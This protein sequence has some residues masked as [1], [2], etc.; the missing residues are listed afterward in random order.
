M[1]RFSICVAS[2]IF[3]V[4]FISSLLQQNA[5]AVN[6]REYTLVYPDDQAAQN[7]IKSEITST[8]IGD[9]KGGLETTYILVK[10]GIL[11]TMQFRFDRDKSNSQ[12]A[13]IYSNQI[14][15]TLP[16]DGST[17]ACSASAPADNIYA[18]F[19]MT[20]GIDPGNPN[21]FFGKDSFRAAAGAWDGGDKYLK[22]PNVS[23]KFDLDAHNKIDWKIH[24]KLT[25]NEDWKDSQFRGN[26]P[27]KLS[28]SQ[29]DN[30]IL[31]KIM[32]NLV[33]HSAYISVFQKLTDAQKD[34]WDAAATT[35]G[36]TKPSE[37][38]STAAATSGDEVDSCRG[39][40]LGWVL[41]PIVD[42]FAS[43]IQGAGS[44]IESM[45]TFRILADKGDG[46]KIQAI[47]GAFVS[48]ANILLI[49]AFMVI[50]FSQS[51]S[52]GLS[53]Y[54]I[55]RMLPRL[56]MGAIFIN[57]SFYI[58]AF[59]IDIS[60]IAG[61]SIVGFMI[62]AGGGDTSI[63]AQINEAVGG[64][65]G[66]VNFFSTGGDVAAGT[67]IGGGLLAGG[68]AAATIGATALLWLAVPLLLAA[69]ISIFATMLVLIAR[70]VILLGLV[71]VSPL[72]F[73]AWLLPNTDQYF[74]KWWSLFTQQL[75]VFPM[76]MVVFGASI[77]AASLI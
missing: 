60:N 31:T 34:A 33:E 11:G 68:V 18:T 41:C 17:S 56:V 8:G 71:L 24:G 26:D 53:N 32:N 2:L 48:M 27:Y 55:K 5:G 70:Q 76:L 62:G 58:C 65:S 21:D 4:L 40:A 12:D 46:G 23:E 42:G 49:V 64:G 1:K 61:T 63:S 29:A 39:G 10:D 30:L 3:S 14:Y 74:R 54:G 25:T 45:L 16:K 37:A 52:V 43:A 77:L 57:L 72:A 67:V 59:L 19:D 13:L 66:G 6:G 38:P 50:V 20:I 47:H 15:C 9:G 7:K 22:I 75:I 73:A 35:A 44:I 51:T 36:L 69:L 28:K